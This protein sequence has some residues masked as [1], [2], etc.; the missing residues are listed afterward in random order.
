MQYIWSKIRTHWALIATL[1]LGIGLRLINITKISLWHDEAFS[2]LLIK[3]NWGEMIYRIGLDVHPP[4]YYIFL[5][6]WHYVFGHSIF[7]LRSMSIFFGVLTIW[8]TYAFILKFFKSKFGAIAAALLIALN[9]FQIQYVSEARMYTMGAF[10]AILSAYLLALALRLTIKVY[11]EQNLALKS[12]MLW[13]YLGFTLSASILTYTHYYLLFTVAA[14]GFYGIVYLYWNFKFEFKK[15]LWLVLSGLGIGL[16]YIPWLNW[17]IYQVKQVGAGYWIPPMTVWSIPQTLYE[18]IIRI[19]NPGKV[20][21]TIVTAFVLLVLYKFIKKYQEPEK[22]LNMF[23]FLAPYGG[24]ILF[25]LLAFLKGSDSSVFLVRYFIFASSFLIM[26]IALWLEEL[27]VRGMKFVILGF[28]AVISLFST[29]YYWNEVKIDQRPG[30]DGLAKFLSINVSPEDKIIAGTSFEYFNYKYYHNYVYHQPAGI[31]P[32]LYTGGS[33]VENLPH[34]A[35]TAILT[36]DEL[37]LDYN[38]AVSPHDTVWIIWTTGFGGSKPSVPTN[39]TEVQEYS[40]AE[41]RPYVGAWVIVTRYR[42]N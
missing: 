29:F 23:G 9:P 39:W 3:Y 25:A 40:F 18:L 31:T 28:L 21:M 11:K 1:L 20:A 35:G 22:W 12:K 33:K 8:I 41:V 42:V 38:A 34:F 6:L 14:L 24:A 15:Y 16:L 30:M 13:A 37:T 26:M 36:N 2:A 32:T 4:M 5:R 7:A 10:F 17:F 27:R 19:A